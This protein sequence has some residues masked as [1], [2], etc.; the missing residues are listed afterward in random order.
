MAELVQHPVRLS[1]SGR[2]DAGVHAL[3]QIASFSSPTDRTVRALRDGLNALL[4]PDVGCVAVDEVPLSFDPRRQAR[5]KHYRYR[6]LDRRARSP[7]RRNRVYHV[8]TPLDAAA[9]YEACV[10][11]C[12]THDFSTFRAARCGAATAVRTLPFWS[13]QRVDDEV[14]LDVRGHGFLRHMIRIVAGSLTEVGRGARDPTWIGAA[15]HARE[16]SA[17]GPTAPAGGL[18][19]LSVTYDMDEDLS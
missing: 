12:G 18:T 1:V 19:L 3:G 14:W 17:A 11:L 4:P 16:R 15:L 6:W 5:E 13:V 7:L 8:R 9:M 2:T 10:P